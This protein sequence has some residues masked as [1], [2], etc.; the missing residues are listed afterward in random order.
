M[1]LA[2]EDIIKH[3]RHI[4]AVSGGSFGILHMNNLEFVI[5]AVN[6][7][8]D[9]LKKAANV[10][11]YMVE[12]HPFLEGNKRTGFEIAK[13]ILASGGKLFEGQPEEI[14]GFITGSVAQGKASREEIK[15]WLNKHMKSTNEKR[16]FN[17]NTQENIEKDKKEEDTHPHFVDATYPANENWKTN[18]YFGQR[19]GSGSHA[20]LVASGARIWYLRDINGE[21]IIKEGKLVANN[22]SR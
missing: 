1:I 9:S 6:Q 15:I 4:L 21:E 5:N 8:K 22:A 19:D 14:I 11:Y 7:E 2:K 16:E 18:I 13:G 20:H 3:N 10:L 17:T 12:G